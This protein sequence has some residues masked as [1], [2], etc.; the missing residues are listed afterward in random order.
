MSSQ[1]GL[2][3]C[4]VHRLSRGQN[5]GGSS[6][7]KLKARERSYFTSRISIWCVSNGINLEKISRPPSF[8]PARFFQTM[9]LKHA[10][11]FFS[12]ER[13]PLS[14]YSSPH[15]HSFFCF[16]FLF[17]FFLSLREKHLV[18]LV[19]FF[20]II[21]HHTDIIRQQEGYH[22]CD[23]HGLLEGCCATSQRSVLSNN[24]K[25]QRLLTFEGRTISTS[26]QAS[27]ISPP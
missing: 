9:T 15:R 18:N 21:I 27:F 6:T 22:N 3:I 16:A 24:L 19:S 11:S 26:F 17:L 2:S 12:A 25:Q 23:D 14:F 20:S 8:D 5:W 13:R 10:L 1:S 7:R 4:T